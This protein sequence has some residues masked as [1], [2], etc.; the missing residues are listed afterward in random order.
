MRLSWPLLMLLLL[1]LLMLLLMLLMLLLLLML[2]SWADPILRRPA[3][4]LT[5]TVGLG[6]MCLG[7]VRKS[8]WT[9]SV[10]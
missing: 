2:C 4:L 3:Y 7:W 8:N 6:T 10:S 9:A 5:D 1:L